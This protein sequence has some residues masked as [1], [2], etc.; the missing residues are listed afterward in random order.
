MLTVLCTQIV[1]VAGH[2]QQIADGGER[3]CASVGDKSAELSQISGSHD[4]LLTLVGLHL[5][6]LRLPD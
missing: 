1:V 3:H 5:N 4:V 6:T 2:S